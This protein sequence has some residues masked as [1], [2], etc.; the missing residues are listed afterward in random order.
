M[1]PF[2]LTHNKFQFSL[3]KGPEMMLRND[4]IETSLKSQK[5]LLNA[6]TVSVLH[7]HLHIVLLVFVCYGELF[8]PG[9]Q[10]V[11]ANGTVRRMLNCKRG[12]VKNA[13]NV[14]GENPLKGTVQLRVNTFN[15][16]LGYDG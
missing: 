4:F 10:L 11:K 14:V 5:L 8:A 1:F 13:A 12:A 3:I 15:V 9:L 6:S 2:P 7:V 16:I